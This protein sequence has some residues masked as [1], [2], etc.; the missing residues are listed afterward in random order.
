MGSNDGAEIAELVG[1]YILHIL[2]S[3]LY[4][5]DIGLYRDDGLAAI[6]ARGRTA[7]KIR[8]ELTKI[9]QSLGLLG[10]CPMQP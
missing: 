2:E 4:I 6:N 10:K 8:K 1:L 5:K 3:K 7:D 9:M